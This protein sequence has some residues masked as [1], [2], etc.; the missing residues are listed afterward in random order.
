[1]FRCV[2]KTAIAIIGKIINECKKPTMWVFCDL[3]EWYKLQISLKLELFFEMFLNLLV[4][5]FKEMEYTLY[6]C[7]EAK[8]LDK[9]SWK[10]V[11]CFVV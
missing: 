11:H 7:E 4:M 5:I 8:Y 6:K 10:M 1:M 3:L 9:Q 2:D